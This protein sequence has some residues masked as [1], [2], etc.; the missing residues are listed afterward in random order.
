MLESWKKY[1]HESDKVNLNRAYLYTTQYKNV[2]P[3][4]STLTKSNVYN[5]RYITWEVDCIYPTSQNLIIL[6]YKPLTFN[7]PPVGD[8]MVV[9]LLK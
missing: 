1:Q 4:F 6:K 7:Y 8:F 3:K 9:Q 5:D 2:L